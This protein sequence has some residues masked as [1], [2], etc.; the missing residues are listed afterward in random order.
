VNDYVVEIKNQ[1]F[2]WLPLCDPVDRDTAEAVE[3]YYK[4]NLFKQHCIKVRVID[5]EE[6]NR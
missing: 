4:R 1:W 2:G 5:L 6:E 3:R